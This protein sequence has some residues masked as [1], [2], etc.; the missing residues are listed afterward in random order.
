MECVSWRRFQ[1][2]KTVEI[3]ASENVFATD[4]RYEV[5]YANLEA[6]RAHPVY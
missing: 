2:I 3:V 1:L 6:T 4:F 5:E